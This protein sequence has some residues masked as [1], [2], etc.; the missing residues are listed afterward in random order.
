[1]ERV[2]KIIWL[3][4]YNG[5]LGMGN[6]DHCREL[7]ANAWFQNGTVTNKMQKH[8]TQ[9]LSEAHTLKHVMD[10]QQT[11]AKISKQYRSTFSARPLKKKWVNLQQGTALKN[12]EKGFCGLCQLKFSVAKPSKTLRRAFVDFVN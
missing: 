7:I 12:P 4:R 2:H 1:M 10:S 5:K 11:H 6:F 8:A 3:F 9:K